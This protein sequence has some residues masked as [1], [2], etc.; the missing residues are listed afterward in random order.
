MVGRPRILFLTE[1]RARRRPLRAN[2]P[3]MDA[4][5]GAGLGTRRARENTTAVSTYSTTSTVMSTRE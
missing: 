2:E 4:G 5:S 1:G 3:Y